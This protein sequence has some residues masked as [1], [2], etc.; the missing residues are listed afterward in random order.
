MGCMRGKGEAWGLFP[1]R[2]QP[3]GP[4]FMEKDPPNKEEALLP[5]CGEAIIWEQKAD[6]GPE[7]REGRSSAAL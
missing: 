6:S 1:G 3:G 5:Q 4:S 2:S 7:S